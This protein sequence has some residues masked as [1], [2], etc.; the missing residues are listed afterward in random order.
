MLD[1]L[2]EVRGRD[3]AVLDEAEG[4]GNEGGLEAV[5][6]EALDLALDHDRHLTR[7]LEQ[8]LGLGDDVG[9]AIAGR[10][11][12]DERDEMGR[13]DGMRHDHARPAWKRLA[14]ERA[15]DVRGRAREDGFRCGTAVELREDRALGRK[16][17]RDAFLDIVGIGHGLGE[18]LSQRYAPKRLRR[19]LIEE[20]GS[21]QGLQSRPDG[22]GY[23]AHRLRVRVEDGDRSAGARKDDGPRPPD[24]AST[25]DA[26]L[27]SRNRWHAALPAF[28]RLYTS[29]RIRP[30]AATEEKFAQIGP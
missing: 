26:D 21:R 15:R 25:Y 9:V 6:D 11:Q 8:R 19:R 30:Q 29:A 27:P 24:Q 7:V 12:L 16:R 23:R 13:I 28:S 22:I 1:R 4:F 5:Q 14:E 2:V 3:V 17:L 18:A 20:P 10:H